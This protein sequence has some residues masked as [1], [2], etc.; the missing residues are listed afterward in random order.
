M[1]TRKDTILRKMDLPVRDRNRC[2]NEEEMRRT[3]ERQL[4]VGGGRGR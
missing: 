3:R 2:S 1:L 4:D